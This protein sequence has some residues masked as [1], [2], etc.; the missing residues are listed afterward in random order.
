MGRAL[1]AHYQ[2][3]LAQLFHIEQP[4]DDSSK[5]DGRPYPIP[6]PGR[7]QPN[8]GDPHDEDLELLA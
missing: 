7:L 8:E 2:H 1:V 3:D 6:G 5:K 4:R